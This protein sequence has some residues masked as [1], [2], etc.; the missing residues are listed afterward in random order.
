MHTVLFMEALLTME[1]EAKNL[2]APRD[3]SY[4]RSLKNELVKI[5]EEAEFLFGPRDRSYELREPMITECYIA[6]VLVYPFRFARIYL[7]NIVKKDRQLASYLLAHEAIHV[8]GP[9]F[10]QSP[11]IL[12]E[13][14]ASYF[15]LRY[16]N[17][18]Y[19]LACEST[20]DPKYDAALRAVSALLAKNEFVI[21][22]LRARQPVISRIDEQ[23]LVEVAGI[24]QGQA[25]FLCSDFHTFELEPSPWNEPIKRG[26][27]LFVNGCRSIWDQWKSA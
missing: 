19:G 9:A 13:G 6:C 20:S 18:V 16:W 4:E 17:R 14:L 22:E 25:K 24:E 10:A 21:K 3:R 15:S 23:V 5:F 1:A 2:L 12:E 27:Q 7:P 26:A 11:T 8:L